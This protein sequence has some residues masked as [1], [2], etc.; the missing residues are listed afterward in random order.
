M[1]EEPDHEE[2]AVRRMRLGA[3]AAALGFDELRVAAVTGPAAQAGRF[4]TWLEDGAHGSLN[5]LAKYRL[6]FLLQLSS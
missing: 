6:C 1:A 4:L 3:V 2:A 5:W